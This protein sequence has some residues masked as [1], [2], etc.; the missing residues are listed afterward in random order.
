MT[1]GYCSSSVSKKPTNQH[2]K[3]LVSFGVMTGCHFI[4]LSCS[5]ANE[6]I[7]RPRESTILV[8]H[9]NGFATSKVN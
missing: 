7:H 6:S 4:L 9:E 3:I 1:L 2:N 8:I 5:L